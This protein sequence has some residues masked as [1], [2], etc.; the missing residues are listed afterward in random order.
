MNY[1]LFNEKIGICWF[2][3]RRYFKCRR[4]KFKWFDFDWGVWGD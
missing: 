2:F 3:F 1:L 4:N